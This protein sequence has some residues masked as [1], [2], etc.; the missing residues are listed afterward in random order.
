MESRKLIQ[1][2]V[3]SLVLSLPREWIKK[4]NL[5][6]GSTVYVKTYPHKIEIFPEKEEEKKNNEVYVIKPKSLYLLKEELFYCFISGKSSII[7][8]YDPNLLEEIISLIKSFPGYEYEISENKIILTNHINKELIDPKRELKRI[9]EINQLT[10]KQYFQDNDLSVSDFVLIINNLK[11]KCLLAESKINEMI[12]NPF[13]ESNNP[14]FSE[15]VRLK[16]HLAMIPIM[17]DYEILLVKHL[18][19]INTNEEFDSLRPFLDEFL[20]LIDEIKGLIEN[21]NDLNKRFELRL[22]L[23]TNI[24][25]LQTSDFE[26]HQTS[27]ALIFNTLFNIFLNYTITY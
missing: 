25:K 20:R 22:R 24:N 10:L 13:L 2:G 6:K 8:K 15:L 26:N 12:K 19:E 9:F 4:H 21:Y 17:L 23:K 5:K 11:R 16:H 27:I 1:S 18:N 7:I 14:D 3:S